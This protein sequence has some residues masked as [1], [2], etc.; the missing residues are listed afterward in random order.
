MHWSLRLA[1][2]AALS[3]SAAED[4][5]AADAAYPKVPAF[6]RF[7]G[8]GEQPELGGQLLLG[9]LNCTAC[10]QAEAAAAT[11]F[12]PK[13]APILDTVGSRVRPEYIRQFLSN[14]QKTK[15]GT[16]MP[17]PFAGW[18]EG[19]KKDAIEALTHYLALSGVITEQRVVPSAVAQGDALYHRI[20]CVA[21][22][23]PQKPGSEPLP[24]SSPLGN[25]GA[26]YTL[27]SLIAYLQD[28]S[29]ART[30]SRMP[31][32]NLEGEEA[33]QLASYLLRD[34]KDIQT[35]S[36]LKYSLYEG[37]YNKLPN[38]AELKPVAQGETSGFDVT[39]VPNKDN[40]ALRFQG[41]INLTRDGDYRFQ[42]SSD[43][44]SRLF[45]D[46]QQ[47]VDHDGI[48]APGTKDGST[49]LKAGRHTITV[50]YFEQAGGEELNV[51]I[52]GGGLSKQPLEN[53]LVVEKQP[54]PSDKP[55]F[56]AD[57][58][59]ASQGKEIFANAGCAACH[60]MN[61]GDQRIASKLE[62]PA[63]ASLKT[64]GG[65]LNADPTKGAPYFNL[66]GAQRK[67]LVAAVESTKKPIPTL[68]PQDKIARTMKS[69]NCV[70]CHQRD[71]LGGVE[72]FRNA[73]FQTTQ[74]EMGDEGRIP[75]PLT[76]VG[77]KLRPEY[78]KQ[79]VEAANKERPYMYTRM[80]R[81]AGFPLGDLITSI[82][83][84]DPLL[85]VKDIKIDTPERQFKQAGY[86]LV[87]AKG[88]S[89]IKCH[90]WGGVQATGIQ[91]INMQRMTTR[92]NQGWFEAYV[93]NPQGFRPGTRMPSAWPEGQ[94]LLPMIL[95]GKADTQI[96]SVW[97]YLTDGDQARI[98]L[99]LG[100]D[101]IELVAET[102]PIMYRNFIEGGGPRAIGVG[103]PE[104]VNY[105]YDA[106]NLRIAMI[107]QGAFMDASK[108]WVDRGAGFQPP[109]GENVL[110]LPAGVPLATLADEKSDWPSQT[111]KELGYQFKGYTYDAKRRPTFTFKYGEITVSEEIVPAGTL[112]KPT[113]KRTLTFKSP[114]PAERVY[115]RVAIDDAIKVEEGGL[116][117]MK[118]GWQTR[119]AGGGK[120]VVRESGGK[121]QLLVPVTFNNGEAKIV[122]EF[123][124]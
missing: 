80:P 49:K 92:L 121:Q 77:T 65:C 6:E 18:A 67:A 3:M 68:T 27:P 112:E 111:A 95:D 28:P 87:G 85:P 21:C 5:L 15:P 107:W 94:V 47:V 97:E 78:L 63:L 103:Y 66:S 9:E 50:D 122:Q 44:G 31:A 26:K 55:Q 8:G 71:E 57:P 99:G 7:H 109:L 58:T 120:P 1:L 45:I 84:V 62:A 106:N 98:P 79:Q 13:P 117:A 2:I 86:N 83:K 32:M 33:R 113:L 64:A 60:Q 52:E 70:A 53:I 104:K 75:P 4:L 51:V 105:A 114:H 88:Y 96:R 36:N 82:N 43:D 91:S 46:G 16:T 10:H 90:T 24:T 76:G 73:H 34:L 39:F 69:L 119:L 108:H 40:F 89:C 102:E 59:L 123:I 115:L 101:P 29:K 17:D 14:P 42:L 81:F 61:S 100:R 30:H 22:H 41:T 23:D 74:K 11:L 38:F 25:L 37:S 110:H 48:H 93:L 124:W 20:G 54:K 56:V 116:F 118:G 72:E 12:H 35:P 19:D